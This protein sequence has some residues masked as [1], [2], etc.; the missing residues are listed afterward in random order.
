LSKILIIA[1]SW[2][3]DTVMAQPLFM[4]LKQR[5]PQARI[6]VFAPAWVGPI[7]RRMPEVDDVIANPFAHG[8]LQLSARWRLGRALKRRG[9]DQ[10]I[11]LP[12]S[13]KSALVPFFAGIP[14]RT[15]YVGEMRYGLLDDA[16]KLDEQACPLMVERF[17]LLAQ[18]ANETLARPVPQPRL[19]VEETQRAAVLRKLGVDADRP[20]VALCPG[21]EYGPA[22]RW[23]E[24]H[25]ASLAR[26]LHGRGQQ[27]W[28]VGSAK[29]QAIGETIR[30]ASG[31]ACRNLCGQTSLDEA[32]DLLASAVA[33]VTNDS[34]LMHVAAALDKPL[35]ALYGSSS[36]H[37]TPPLSKRAHIVSLNLACSPCF[38]RECPLGHLDCLRK[39]APDTVLAALISQLGG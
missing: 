15:G 22:K 30:A 16:R 13:F 23:P 21:A 26:T 6:D 10:A 35:V 24:A 31:D 11:V 34:G 18:P 2:V 17:A 9:Y 7:L 5:N 28:L 36:P 14:R 4:R 32:V 27:V 3:G 12:N 25:F 20:A 37:F 8:A 29:D 39:L 1:P 33:V 38:Q 19:E